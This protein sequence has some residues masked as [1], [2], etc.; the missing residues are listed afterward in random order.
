MNRDNKDKKKK[1]RNRD[2]VV[3]F[4]QISKDSWLEM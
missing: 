4:N 1:T 3:K 2:K